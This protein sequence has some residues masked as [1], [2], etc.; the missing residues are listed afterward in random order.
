[1]CN[2]G[3]CTIVSFRGYKF[4]QSG[5]VASKQLDVR[6]YAW[7]VVTI[8]CVDN[9]CA[10]WR[11]TSTTNTNNNIESLIFITVSPLCTLGHGIYIY[12]YSKQ[13]LEHIV[14]KSEKTLEEQ[15]QT[16]TNT[17]VSPC[18]ATLVSAHHFLKQCL[19]CYDVDKRDAFNSR[20]KHKYKRKNQ[21]TMACEQLLRSIATGII[22]S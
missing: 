12:I 15:A 3:I 17:H 6:R 21:R 4:V 11:H 14:R 2:R 8:I 20:N 9:M 18:R 5:E 13:T 22:L 16:Y 7:L 10:S 19:F 1:M